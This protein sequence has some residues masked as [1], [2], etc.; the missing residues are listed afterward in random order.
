MNTA[1]EKVFVAGDPSTLEMPVPWMTTKIAAVV[2]WSPPKL[3]RPVGYAAEG[4]AREATG[5][6]QKILSESQ[7]PTLSSL[8]CWSFWFCFVQI[9]VTVPWFL[10][11][12]FNLLLILQELS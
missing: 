1:Q 6:A 8:Q 3:R 9:V 10:P 7:M 5:G 12:V 11:F 4:G 2:E